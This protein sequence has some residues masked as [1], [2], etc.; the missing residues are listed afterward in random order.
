[1][2]TYINSKHRSNDSAS[3][4][5]DGRGRYVCDDARLRDQGVGVAVS[6]VFAMPNGL[7]SERVTGR[8][9]VTQSS[10]E[11]VIDPVTLTDVQ[12][13]DWLANHCQRLTDTPNI[14]WYSL[15]AKFF[16]S[17]V[18]TERVR[19]E[20]RR[21]ERFAGRSAKSASAVS[22]RFML[23]RQ[24]RSHRDVTRCGVVSLPT[25]V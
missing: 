4:K 18:V 10:D 7:F 8:M 22:K 3:L 14:R 2:S 15:L 20:A 16:A 12:Q 6:D 5:S 19:R 13:L 25:F 23:T 21:A 17:V 1:M 11:F 9:V 24:N